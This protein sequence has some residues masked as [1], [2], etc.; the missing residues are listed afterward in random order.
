MVVQ[1][2]DKERGRIGLKLVAK[3]EDGQLVR[4]R[5][6]SS[7]RRTRPAAT[8]VLRVTI[9]VAAAATAAGASGAREL[10]EE[11]ARAA[12]PSVI[13]GLTLALAVLFAVPRSGVELET[14]A[15][16]VIQP[17]PLPGSSPNP[18]DVLAPL[19]SELAVHRMV[20]VAAS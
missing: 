10:V 2:V 3:H 15:V 6:S 5:R 14:C 19:A 18:N 17:L 9:A 1:E 11:V 7:G 16:F 12:P 8:R 20:R 4:R 13:Q